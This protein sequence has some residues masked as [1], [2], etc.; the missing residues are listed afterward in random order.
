MPEETEKEEISSEQIEAIRQKLLEQIESMPPEQAE[1]LRE[2]IEEMSDAELIEFLKR[3]GK[4]KGQSG[5]VQEC[6]FCLIS[7]G[8]IESHKIYEDSEILAVLDINPISNGHALIIPKKHIS[9]IEELKATI[10]EKVRMIASLIKN[11]LKADNIEILTNSRLGHVSINIIPIYNNKPVLDFERQ[12][13]KPE[14]LKKTA[15]KIA[16][17]I[18][19]ADTEEK[20]QKEEYEKRKAKELEQ[21][22]NIKIKRR[23]P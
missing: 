17:K 15:D 4:A 12:K 19:D 14:E 20:K 5:Q 21:L 3:Q 8:K 16:K 7:E 6:I 18:K 2:Q 22:K 11:E 10:W 13:A 9:K 1:Q 23:I